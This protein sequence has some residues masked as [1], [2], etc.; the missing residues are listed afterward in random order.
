MSKGR[1]NSRDQNSVEA[2]LR[3]LDEDLAQDQA[4]FE[5]RRRQDEEWEKE[6][7]D[8]WWPLFEADFEHF[9]DLYE[10]Q[11][12]PPKILDQLDPDSDE[13]FD[14]LLW[15][16]APDATWDYLDDYPDGV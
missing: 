11:V 2:Q 14:E 4:E 1:R 9:V 13:Y 3:K 8:S 10:Q 15:S 7:Q 12:K 6:Q 5:E 16:Q